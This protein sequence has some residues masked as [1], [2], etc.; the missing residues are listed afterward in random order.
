MSITRLV[1][2][3]EKYLLRRENN[4]AQ[5][6][7]SKRMQAE[8]VLADR[9]AIWR[10]IWLSLLTW[11][12]SIDCGARGTVQP[13][14]LARRRRDHPTCTDMPSRPASGWVSEYL[15]VRGG[16]TGRR[17][18]AAAAAS[19]F[20]DSR[21]QPL[22]RLPWRRSS[23]PAASHVPDARL[24]RATRGW[25]RGGLVRRTQTVSMPAA[26]WHIWLLS[27]AAAAAA[28]LAA[29]TKPGPGRGV[30][31]EPAAAGPPAFGRSTR[32]A[33]CRC[34]PAPIDYCWQRSA[35]P[36]SS[37]ESIS[38]RR[39]TRRVSTEWNPA[40]NARTMTGK[41][42]SISFSQFRR[43]YAVR[44]FLY[45]CSLHSASSSSIEST[46]GGALVWASW[47]RRPPNNFGRSDTKQLASSTLGP[48]IWYFNPCIW[49]R[50]EMVTLQFN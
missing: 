17:R 10:C 7:L 5:I 11:A 26:A 45:S 35:A 50:C 12:M 44:C 34:A 30:A 19:R 42:A 14:H 9:W 25:Q 4:R 48:C 21:L 37:I 39:R 3:K 6:V 41:R 16:D 23:R 38:M 47:P 31:W 20:R 18:Q 43:N 49:N 32:V 40:Q 1:R 28:A 27:A 15:W 36:S 2:M 33:T 8:L 29:T 24:Q 22:P 13:V 46:P